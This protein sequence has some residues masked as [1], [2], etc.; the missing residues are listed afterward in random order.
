MDADDWPVD[1]SIALS[2]PHDWPFG[3]KV[4]ERNLTFRQAI[5]ADDIL[6]V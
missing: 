5:Y 2:L 4:I 1:D 3:I 6:I